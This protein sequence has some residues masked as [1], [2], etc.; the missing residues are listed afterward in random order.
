MEAFRALE[1]GL[2]GS[3]S[4]HLP[5]PPVVAYSLAIYP[6]TERMMF[7]L[8]ATQNQGFTAADVADVPLRAAHPQ[9]VQWMDDGCREPLLLISS[10]DRD[11]LRR[12]RDSLAFR[13]LTARLSSS[14]LKRRADT[15]DDRHYDGFTHARPD[16]RC[17]ADSDSDRL[18]RT[19]P[20]GQGDH[21][22]CSYREW[23][24]AYDLAGFRTSLDVRGHGRSGLSA[25]P[26]R[27]R[28]QPA[29]PR[30]NFYSV[31]GIGYWPSKHAWQEFTWSFTLSAIPSTV[32]YWSVSASI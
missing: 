15:V 22:I 16:R 25:L 32:M 8:C 9:L 10:L 17:G 24:T 3:R 30:S 5:E 31:T 21:A 11:R 14:R 12:L 2:K 13:G 18:T 28:A 27:L 1:R 19:V 20:G 29:V 23:S 26:H 4:G 7:H 6:R